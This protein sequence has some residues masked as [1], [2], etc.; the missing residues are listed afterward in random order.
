M[1]CSQATNGKHI[2]VQAHDNWALHV[3]KNRK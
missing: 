1:L 2:H 3:A